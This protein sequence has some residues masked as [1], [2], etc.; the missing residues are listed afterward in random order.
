MVTSLNREE[1]SLT[2]LLLLIEILQD[3]SA[4]LFDRDDAAMQLGAYDDPRAL[5]ALLAV[6]QSPS[7]DVSILDVVGE[8]IAQIWLR[9]QSFDRQSYGRLSK[10]SKEA[11]REMLELHRPPWLSDL[12]SETE[13]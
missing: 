5:S 12:D 11:A 13:K 2:K 8:S 6:G 7:T 9:N 1:I 4:S 3:T 10:V